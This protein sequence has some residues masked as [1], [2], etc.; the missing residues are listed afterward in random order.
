MKYYVG[1]VQALSKY[2]IYLANLNTDNSCP[3]LN[4]ILAGAARM[5]AELDAWQSKRC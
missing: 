3:D 1:Q 2:H 4:V 5:A